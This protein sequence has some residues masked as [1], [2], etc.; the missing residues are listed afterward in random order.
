M[1]IKHKLFIL[2]VSFLSSSFSSISHCSE[3]PELAAKD[4]PL[5]LEQAV[6]EGLKSNLD[7]LAAHYGI[8]ISEADEITAGLWNNPAILFDTVFQ[9]VQGTN[10]NQTNA[11]GPK[12]FDVI[13]SYPLD[14]SGKRG[15]AEKS[16]HQAVSIAKATFE[17]AL[18]L[19]VQDIRLAY[20]DVITQEHQLSLTQEK[21]ATLKNLVSM[22]ENR[23]GH[24]GR[25]PLLLMRAQLA[26]SQAKLD[27]RQREIS[28]RAAD[29]Q[30]STLLAKKPGTTRLNTQTKLKDFKLTA[31]PDEETLVQEALKTRPDL[32]ALQLTSTKSDLDAELAHAQVWDNFNL[33][34]GYSRQGP[35]D[36]N[37]ADPTTV[38]QGAANSWNAGITI[39]LPFFNRSQGNIQKAKMSK[40][41]AG[42]QIESKILAIHQEIE[43][44]CDQLRLGSALIQEYEGGQLKRARE[45]RDAQQRQ[46]GTGNSALL[47]YL[48]AVSAYQS[49]VSAYYDAVADYQRNLARLNASIG[50]DLQ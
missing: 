9:P 20:I 27:N 13:I 40:E 28:L 2:L 29:V 37:P 8:P 49:S 17:D 34:A 35:N 39:P 14:L 36:P 46:F 21:E 24:T 3:K 41:Q 15:K 4:T 33:T 26:W 5:T 44:L 31:I 45:V 7:I 19:K 6:S 16:A 22:T 43:G 12:Q 25:L 10:W 30:L 42:R 11:G 50:K 1:Q 32:K 47:D 38:T 23:V 18:R 48:D